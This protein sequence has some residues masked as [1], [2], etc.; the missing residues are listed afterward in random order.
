MI[1][2]TLES[3]GAQ[4]VGVYPVVE[5]LGLS[6]LEICV[7]HL[8][9]CGQIYRIEKARQ[10]KKWQKGDGSVGKKVNICCNRSTPKLERCGLQVLGLETK[11]PYSVT[12]CRSLIHIHVSLP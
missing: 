4:R 2:S 7:Q 1:R 10:A 12:P 6:Q 11:T 9:T 5:G 3:Y 8:L